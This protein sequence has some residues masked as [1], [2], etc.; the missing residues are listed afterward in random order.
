MKLSKCVF[1]QQQLEY[2][3]HLITPAGVATEP[4]KISAVSRWPTPTNV[5]QLRGFLGL[6]GYYRRFIKHYGLISKP[7]T[8]LLKKGVPFQWTSQV[9]Q[10]FQLLKSA[11]LSAPVL[12]IPDFSKPFVVETD[13][14]D[15][16]IGAVLMQEGHPISYLSQPLCARNT[17]LSTYEKEC[18]VVLLAVDKW[19]P[20]LMSQ[21]FIIRTDHR[22]LLFLTDQKATTKL[23]Q[24]A[25][26]KLIDL[27]FKIQYKQGSTNAAADALS[28][29][30]ASNVSELH[31]ISACTPSWMSHLQE[32]YADDPEA[33]QLLVELS[34]SPTNDKGF[35]LYNGIIKYKGRVWVG[36]NSLA[37][38]HIL[39]ALHAS[40][41]GGHSGIQAT[42]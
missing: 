1:A 31:A 2:L 29:C 40:G 15:L 16:G 8:H 17:A 20:Y 39:H 22:S 32:G 42:Y 30:P 41:I 34:I 5:K 35:S 36:H 6:T 10:A 14:S 3:G 19:R 37:Q 4:S 7:L 24:K 33:Q 25:L 26:L 28:R 9:Q 38:S 21:E 12:A 13:A 23:Q 11:L 27:Q 18:M